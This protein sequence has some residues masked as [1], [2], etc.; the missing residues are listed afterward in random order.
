[1]MKF[2]GFVDELFANAYSMPD[3]LH[4]ALPAQGVAPFTLKSTY[5]GHD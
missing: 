2:A 4:F 3:R 5:F 1:M